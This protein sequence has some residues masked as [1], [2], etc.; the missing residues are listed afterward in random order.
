MQVCNLEPSRA[1]GKIKSFIE[2]AILDGIIPNE[3]EAAKKYFLENKDK[4]LME[5]NTKI[6]K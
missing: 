2:E 3:Y 4:W 1:V 6:N 5:I